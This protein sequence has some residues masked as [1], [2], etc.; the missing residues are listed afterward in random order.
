MPNTTSAAV[1]IHYNLD[2]PVKDDI[3][4]YLIG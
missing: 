2:T 3:Y 1:E 4:D